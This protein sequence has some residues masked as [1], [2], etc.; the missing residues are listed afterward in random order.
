[1]AVAMERYAEALHLTRDRGE[2]ETSD[3]HAARRAEFDALRP[4][5]RALEERQFLL[6]FDVAASPYDPDEALYRLRV[7][8]PGLL[9]PAYAEVSANRLQAR[10]MKASLSHAY[11]VAVIRSARPH[12]QRVWLK[13]G[14][15]DMPLVFPSA[16]TAGPTYH[17]LP[18]RILSADF[19]PDGRRLAAAD[20]SGP[21]HLWDFRRFTHTERMIPIELPRTRQD[22]PNAVAFSPDGTTVVLGTHD[23]LLEYWRP[24]EDT[25]TTLPVGHTNQVRRVRFFP[26]GL[27]LVSTG[28]D[29]TA[30]VWSFSEAAPSARMEGHGGGVDDVAFLLNGDVA[31]GGS[32]GAIR[33]WAGDSGAPRRTLYEQPGHIRSLAAS[34]T[35]PLLAAGVTPTG[36]ILV[37]DTEAGVLVR[38]WVALGAHIWDMLFAADGRILISAPET[39]R[40]H[41]YDVVSGETLQVTELHNDIIG[42]LALSKDGA[43]LAAGTWGGAVQMWYRVGSDIAPIEPVAPSDPAAIA[44]TDTGQQALDAMVAAAGRRR[45]EAA[46]AYVPAPERVGPRTYAL[47]VGV[48]SYDNFAGLVNPISD[49][50]AV[51]EELREN[52]GVNTLLLADPSRAE[53]LTQL[54]ALAERHYDRDDQLL[55]FFSGHGWFDEVLKR[56]YLAMRDAAPLDEDVFRD[57]FVSHEDVRAVLERLACRHVLLIVD[58]CFSGKLDPTVA[59][60]TS[61]RGSGDGMYDGIPRDEYIERKMEFVTRRYITAGGKEFVPDGRPGEHSPFARQLL[62]ALR[63]LGGE[64]GILTFEEMAL[65]LKRVEPQPLSGELLGN[66]PGSSF[67]LVT[68]T[69]RPSAPQPVYGYLDLVVQ[70]PGATVSVRRSSAEGHGPPRSLRIEPVAAETRRY[71]LPEGTYTV[72]VSHVGHSARTRE[73]TITE[74]SQKLRIVLSPTP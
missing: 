38:S 28:W 25:L 65:Y 10:R 47:L 41:V 23:A 2:F 62:A 27:R 69:E 51:E 57:T 22:H 61:G 16:W 15:G 30:R 50:A 44:G 33:V 29:D 45:Q 66:E 3:E 56:G 21:A 13:T 55:V 17:G 54:H 5:L 7:S 31:T 39:R 37:I 71:R 18:G 34:P 49:A 14:A 35:L 46:P 9:A 73:V 19:S 68:R 42:S 12:V 36:D 64:G 60:A 24:V 40:I 63:N 52:Y 20:V 32:D 8:K 11:G 58:S 67:V 53:F 74:A 59:M 48:D 70:P 26:D 1:M 72:T 6:T 4:E 43:L